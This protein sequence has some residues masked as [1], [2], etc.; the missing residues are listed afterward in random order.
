MKFKRQ[1]RAGLLAGLALVLG[2]STLPSAQAA[3]SPKA[4]QSEHVVQTIGPVVIDWSE[5][6]IR[7]TGSGTPLDNSS[8]TQSRLVAERKATANAYLSL[9]QAVNLI[10]V[11]SDA[12]VKDYTDDDPTVMSYVNSLIKGAQKMDQ[13]Y[14]DNG[15]IEV[16]LM[17]K[18][19]SVHGLS[20]VLQPQ[21][22]AAPPL[23]AALE[24]ETDPGD[25]TGVIVDC[26]GLGL[27]P[28]MSPAIMSQAGGEVYLSNLNV[29]PTFVI[30]EGVVGY[31][32]SL[33]QARQLKRIGDHPLIIK[34][35]SATGTFR[36]DVIISEDDTK[37]L[38]GL[39]QNSHLL[40]D[41]KIIFV[42]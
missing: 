18:L 23:P 14:L 7:V 41:A 13:R 26:R 31:A 28:A 9:I 37:Q 19:Y 42:M 21:K 27:E 33:E 5:G 39:D 17:V 3:D 36:T 4:T 12:L 24:P 16:D 2:L 8:S 11:N 34:G 20:G 30:D 29:N 35:T 40:K 1:R 22:H 38:L 10:R 25:Y 15:K 32:H 6:V